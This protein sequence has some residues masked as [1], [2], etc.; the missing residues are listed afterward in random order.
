MFCFPADLLSVSQKKVNMHWS[1]SQKP[2]LA[3]LQC[4][5][6]WPM[7][8]Q[9]TSHM[10]NYKPACFMHKQH[11]HTHTHKQTGAQARSQPHAKMSVWKFLMSE[12]TKFAKV[13]RGPSH[14]SLWWKWLGL[15]VTKL[16]R[17][18]NHPHSAEHGH[19]RETNK[20]KVAKAK[21]IRSSEPAS[22]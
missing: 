13:N 17:H 2:E 6:L 10:S 21:A 19:L 14:G 7:T 1:T 11:T 9:S 8:G 18:I 20:G 16:I 4:F 3:H 22:E 15:S 5:W 12:E